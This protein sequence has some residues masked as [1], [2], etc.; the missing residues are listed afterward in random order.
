MMLDGNTI[1]YDVEN[2]TAH[3]PLNQVNA[4][5]QIENI[6]LD[7]CIQ[8]MISCQILDISEYI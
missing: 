4:Y 1:F 3:S 2:T 7:N 5:L 8:I 6:K